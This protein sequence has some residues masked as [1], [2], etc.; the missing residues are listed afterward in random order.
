MVLH[1]VV[2]VERVAKP[3]AAKIRL[4]QLI[5]MNEKQIPFEKLNLISIYTP[6]H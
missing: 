4:L 1:Q 5:S 2:L 6:T 3:F